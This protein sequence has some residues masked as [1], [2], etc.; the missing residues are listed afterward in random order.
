MS[1]LLTYQPLTK[2]KAWVDGRTYKLERNKE[3]IAIDDLPAEEKSA[4]KGHIIRDES[5]IPPAL[6]EERGR[7]NL[8]MIDLKTKELFWEAVDRPLTQEEALEELGDKLETLIEKQDEIIAL[9]KQN[10]LE[11]K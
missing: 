4:L 1:V 6:P 3:L 9:L 5:E 10:K 7:S 8:L 11:L 2:D